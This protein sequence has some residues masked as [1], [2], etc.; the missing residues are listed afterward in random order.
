MI[1]TNNNYIINKIE[2]FLSSFLNRKIFL[3]KKKIETNKINNHEQKEYLQNI[4]YI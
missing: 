2:Q 3:R 1:L 4:L